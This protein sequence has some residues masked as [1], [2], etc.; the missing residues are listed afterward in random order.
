M[1]SK[2]I[3]G[4]LLLLASHSAMA[5]GNCSVTISKINVAENGLQ[6]KIEVRE[7]LFTANDKHE[8]YD[9][10]QES[11]SFYPSNRSFY[12]P[13]TRSDGSQSYLFSGR[14]DVYYFADYEFSSDSLKSVHAQGKG[15]IQN[16]SHAPGINPII[17]KNGEV[18]IK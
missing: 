7:H 18:L 12:G 3:V 4:V 2:F 14:V 13:M 11:L 10:A 8:C 16:E 1:N 15:R 5:Q 17:G 9:L 6:K